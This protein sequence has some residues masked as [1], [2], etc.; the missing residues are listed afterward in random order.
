VPAWLSP[1]ALL[2]GVGL[3][4]GYSLLG[5]S[6]LV[7]K[8]DGEVRHLAYQLISRLSL[9]LLVFLVVVFAFA[10]LENLPVMARWLNRPYLLVFPAVGAVAAIRLATSVRRR[11]DH[12]PFDMVAV[13]FTAAFGTLAITFWPYMIPFSITIDAAAAPHSSLAFMFWGA[14]LFVFP[15]TLLYTAFNYRA[16]RGKIQP[17]A[18]YKAPASSCRIWTQSISVRS[19]AWAI[20]FNVSPTTP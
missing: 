15:L 8:C 6:W 13:I 20:R 18:D 5:A 17:G 2:C 11:Y 12:A 14:G 10:L 3:C 1:F 7:R 9:A 4:I 19:M 16:F